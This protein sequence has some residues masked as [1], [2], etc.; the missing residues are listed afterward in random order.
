MLI[1]EDND[2]ICR[3]GPGTPMGNVFRRYWHP[4]CL[5]AQLPHN[6]CDPLALK[7]LGQSFVA[8]RDTT[9]KVGLLDERC[10]HR[11]TSLALGRV[12]KCGIRCIYHGWKFD[13][14]GALMDVPN[15][16][17]PA[18]MKKLRAQAYP[19]REA[20]GMVWAYIGSADKQPAFPDFAFLELP[21]EQRYIVR[22]NLNTNYLQNLEGGLDS[23]H[24]SSL[25]SDFF[26]P[27]WNDSTI[28]N[29]M[30]DAA[31][32]LEVEDTEFGYHY[33]SFRTINSE[34]GKRIENI[35]IMPFILPSSRIIPG[36]RR[37]SIGGGEQGV[38]D[39]FIIETPLDDENTSAYMIFYGNQ[40]I[41]HEGRT[42][43]T[44]TQRRAFLVD[45]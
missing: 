21:E 17:D 22:V 41:D 31:P 39:I 8:F 11:G 45:R 12:E 30:D 20:G 38:T 26:R 24:S 25:H 7:L 14:D 3:T 18:Y 6:D 36:R 16:P 23:S 44:R 33:A 32:R 5:T 2:L 9:G 4:I 42:F 29:V 10:L 15:Y 27:G 28:D 1:K 40:K 13:V 37:R 43:P 34:D 19:V 35:R